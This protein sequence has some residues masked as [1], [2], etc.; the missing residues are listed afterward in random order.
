MQLAVIRMENN[1]DSDGA[2]FEHAEKLLKEAKELAS[3]RS[4]SIAHLST[5]YAEQHKYKQ[6]QPE[7]ESHRN[8]CD[9]LSLLFL[10]FMHRFL[11]GL[12]HDRRSRFVI[13]YIGS[14]LIQILKKN[15]PPSLSNN[16]TS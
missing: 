10:S 13:K 6:A 8:D 15:T 14:P 2:A 3:T 9:Y 4:V 5:L 11:D 7:M 1:N 16:S 12:E